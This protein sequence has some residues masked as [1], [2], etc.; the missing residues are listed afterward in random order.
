[1]N[2][3]GLCVP[4]VLLCARGSP[5]APVPLLSF[6]AGC[7]TRCAAPPARAPSPSSTA[8]A[9]CCTRAW[10]P[11][12]ARRRAPPCRA[13]SA[14]GRWRPGLETTWLTC[15]SFRVRAWCLRSVRSGCRGRAVWEPAVSCSVA[16]SLPPLPSSSILPPTHPPS[17]STHTQA[18][19]SLRP[20]CPPTA[21]RRSSSRWGPTRCWWSAATRSAAS[22]AWTRCEGCVGGNSCRWVFPRSGQLGAAAQLPV[23]CLPSRLAGLTWPTRP[24]AHLLAAGLGVCGGR[25]ARSPAGAAGPGQ[26][27]QAAELGRRALDGRCCWRHTAAV[28]QAAACQQRQPASCPLMLSRHTDLRH[29][30]SCTVQLSDVFTLGVGSLRTQ[31]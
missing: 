4:P 16:A 18:A 12:A 22:P 10:R 6:P 2:G 31:H 17:A 25:Q 30:H 14:S 19:S 8:A 5:P 1:M 27:L 28:V 15:S 29:L 7:G 23:H 9:A 26:R 13:P 20:T 21:R 3:A 24:A 11:R